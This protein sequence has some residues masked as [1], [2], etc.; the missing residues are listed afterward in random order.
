MISG[1]K[2]QFEN[3][4]NEEQNTYRSSINTNKTVKTI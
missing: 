4:F 1:T 3:S 2:R